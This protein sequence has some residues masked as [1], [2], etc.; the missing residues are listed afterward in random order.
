MVGGDDDCC[1]ASHHYFTNLYDFLLLNENGK[2]LFKPL[3]YI[4]SRDLEA[5][6]TSLFLTI[7]LFYV[8]DFSYIS[9]FL[10]YT[11]SAHALTKT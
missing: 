9:M 1:A 8:S 7:E 2:Y 10:K 6:A 4:I 3:P 5:K 11:F